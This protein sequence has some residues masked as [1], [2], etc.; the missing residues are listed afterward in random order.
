MQKGREIPRVYDSGCGDEGVTMM[1]F[2]VALNNRVLQFSVTMSK[3]RLAILVHFHYNQ[4][5]RKFHIALNTSLSLV[6]WRPPDYV[7]CD[8]FVACST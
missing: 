8:L 7:P 2:L 5:E 4:K 6:R 3:D 1:E